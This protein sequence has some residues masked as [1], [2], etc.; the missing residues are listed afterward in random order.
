MSK[1]VRIIYLKTT[2]INQM[3][4]KLMFEL[5]KYLKK[6]AKIM[7]DFSYERQMNNRN[8]FITIDFSRCASLYWIEA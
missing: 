6:Q 8:N 7:K 4:K 2:V 5:S 3:S 1:Y